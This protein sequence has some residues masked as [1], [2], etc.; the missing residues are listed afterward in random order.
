MV[1]APG[2]GR[3]ARRRFGYL[4]G[5]GDVMPQHQPEV[6]ETPEEE[7]DFD[8]EEQPQERP[9]HYGR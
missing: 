8:P 2:S 7:A 4:G 5:G 9:P 3:K 6:P 1:P